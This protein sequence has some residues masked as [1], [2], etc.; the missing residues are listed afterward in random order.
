[1]CGD[2]RH[3]DLGQGQ[4]Q[5][6]EFAHDNADI[7]LIKPPTSTRSC[8]RSLRAGLPAENRMSDHN[9]L[10][11][12]A[13]RPK[14]HTE[15]EL[16]R[17]MSTIL[18][19]AKNGTLQEMRFFAEGMGEF[20]EFIVPEV[21]EAFLEHLKAS[22][23][24]SIETLPTSFALKADCSFK[25]PKVHRAL[26]ALLGLANAAP[27]SH[28]IQTRAEIGELLVARWPGVL[29]WMWYFFIACFEKSLADG[30][31]RARIHRGLCLMFAVGCNRDKCTAE[32]GEIPGTIRLSTSICM[33]DLKGAF[34]DEEDTWLGTF[35]LSYFLEVKTSASLLDE[36]LE[37]VGGNSKRFVDTIIARLGRALETLEMIE[38][39]ASVYVALISILDLFPKHPLW[40]ALRS[41]NP[42]IILTKALHRLLEVLPQASSGRFNPDSDSKIQHLIISILS[43]ISSVMREDSARIKLA[44]QALQAG[45]MTAL[46]D[47]APIAFTFKAVDRDAMV[48][49][50]KQFSWLTTRLPV[51][52]QAS[53]ELEKLERSCS[54]QTRFNASTLDV[55]NAWLTFYDAIL[56]RRTI[57]TQMQAL[58]STPM[59]CDNCFRFDER[60]NFKKCAGC[61]MAHYCSKDCQSQAWKERGHRAECKTLKNKPVKSR[62]RTANQERYFLA[63]VAVNDAQHRKEHLKQMARMGLRHISVSVDYTAFP[64]RCAAE[65]DHE[66]LESYAKETADIVEA[67]GRLLERCRSMDAQLASLPLNGLSP[68]PYEEVRV[69]NVLSGV[70]RVKKSENLEKYR[71]RLGDEDAQSSGAPSGL[72]P[73]LLVVCL[74]ADEGQLPREERFVV[75]DFWDFVHIK[76][77]DADVDFPEGFQEKDTENKYGVAHESYSPEVQEMVRLALLRKSRRASAENELAERVDQQQ[78]DLMRIM[79]SMYNTRVHSLRSM[80]ALM[81]LMTS[82]KLI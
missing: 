48:D 52:R 22:E 41:R 70:S 75:D 58:N 26:E 45:I 43:H 20:S 76:L 38:R 13:K 35:S 77:E 50:L 21:F 68:Q 11:E 54:V 39:S 47:C 24:P 33:L 23:T 51:A 40:I 6:F 15:Q 74:P 34:M 31:L 71:I 12:R 72:P 28:L 17:I 8:L 25:N 9:F 60:A 2:P 65:Y 61:G 7:T 56:A 46:I 4:G 55:R 32:I 19:K 16:R 63:R 78:V 66:D 81:H 59:A 30:F 62:R 82:L 14:Q 79:R 53:A 57:L 49:V 67:T 1:M 36:V 5:L 3:R 27:F 18:P 42:I 44:L 37:A 29:S 73:V 64:P 10:R 80:T 69:P